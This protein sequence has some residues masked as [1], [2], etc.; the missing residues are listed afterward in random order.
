[1]KKLK[2]FTLGIIALFSLQN[3]TENYSNGERIGVITQFSKTGLGIEEA[4]IISF[5]K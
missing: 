2:L 1:M 3:C 4:L 5:L